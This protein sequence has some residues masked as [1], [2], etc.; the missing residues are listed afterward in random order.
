MTL[1]PRTGLAVV[2]AALAGMG[3]SLQVF[4]SGR[5]AESVGSAELAGAVN[6]LGGI[7]VLLVVGLATGVPLRAA[8]R[9]GRR[10]P[11]RWW[12]V[13]AGVNGGA[14]IAVAAYAAPR[15]GVALLTVALVAG[16]TVGSLLVD[17]AGLSP[18]GPRPFTVARVLS[19]GLAIS[20]VLIAALGSSGDP[21]P[22][23][24]GLALV[25]GA[26][27]A[28]QQAA[29]GHVSRATGEPVAA[30]TVNLAAGAVAIV[31][32]ALALTGGTP[33]R[34]W[35]APP[36]E[37][38]SGVAAAAITI[39]LALVVPALGVLRV[40]LAMVAGQSAGALVLDLVAPPGA[41]VVT[42]ATVAGVAL[43]V[44]AVVVSGLARPAR[45]PA[46]AVQPAS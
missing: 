1:S 36:P 32:V 45:P 25:I 34:G 16:Q 14:Y 33:P 21:R 23:L 15:V 3:V 20:A 12:H 44:V 11:L 7:A 5:F 41:D 6:N 43:T 37:W 9:L 38:L 31:L 28:I 40:M 39:T 22:G 42:A 18:A 17:R 19:V 26:L 4:I 35:S 46:P 13:V 29:M 27:A 10:P 30:A 24:L 2:A 8:R